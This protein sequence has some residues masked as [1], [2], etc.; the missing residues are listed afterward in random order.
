MKVLC[1]VD[2]IIEEANAS[3]EEGFISKNQSDEIEEELRPLFLD[4]LEAR[5]PV[6][7]EA[8]EDEYIPAV[9]RKLAST[10]GVTQ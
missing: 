4:T 10:A 3:V 5:M 6:L 1:M 9:L 2:Y 8:L 7:L